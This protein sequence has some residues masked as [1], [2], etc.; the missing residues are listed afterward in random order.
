M[1]KHCMINLLAKKDRLN[2]LV[3]KLSSHVKPKIPRSIYF[4]VFESRL[5]QYISSTVGTKPC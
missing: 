1:W 3:F 4:A 5:N 2:A